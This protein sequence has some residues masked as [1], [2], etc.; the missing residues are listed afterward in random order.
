MYSTCAILLFAVVNFIAPRNFSRTFFRPFV[1]THFHSML[2]LF[3]IIFQIQTSLDSIQDNYSIQQAVNL[4]TASNLPSLLSVSPQTVTLPVSYTIVNV[5]PFNQPVYDFLPFHL[6]SSYHFVFSAQREC[7]NICWFNLF[8]NFVVLRRC[9]WVSYIHFWN[10]LERNV[11]FQVVAL[12]A[13][14]ASRL[15]H[16]LRFRSIVTVRL[17]SSFI[18]YF[19]LSVCQTPLN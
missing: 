15:N 19:F 3:I 11:S 16:L 4:S 7:C 10:I 9:K 13:R 12:G 6:F 14:E 1:S 18:A 5:V 17:V 8:S 2:C